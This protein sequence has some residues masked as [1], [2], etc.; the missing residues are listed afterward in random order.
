MSDANTTNSENARQRR[1]TTIQQRILNRI[2]KI[3]GQKLTPVFMPSYEHTEN[4][5]PAARILARRYWR[6]ARHREI[7]TMINDQRN[8]SR[9]MNELK[10]DQQPSEEMMRWW[11]NRY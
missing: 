11:M 2:N 7:A 5:T 9:F 1:L 10:S 4:W 8:I 6:I 3:I